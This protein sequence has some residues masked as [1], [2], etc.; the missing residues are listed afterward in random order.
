MGGAAGAGEFMRQRGRREIGDTRR[1]QVSALR[2][3]GV[4]MPDHRQIC[5]GF[6]S[7]EM[8]RAIAG[9]AS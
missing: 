4:A 3:Y 8:G 1:N 2:I 9:L 5:L 6:D 7:I